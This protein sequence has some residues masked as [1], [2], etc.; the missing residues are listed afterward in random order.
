MVMKD[1]EMR[2]PKT[3]QDIKFLQTGKDTNGALLEM[4]ATYNSNSKEPASHYH[5]YQVEDFTVLKGELSVRINGELKI[6]KEGKTL[7]IDANTVHSMWNHKKGK[8]VVNWKVRPAM[9]TENLLRT[10]TGLAIDGK[11]NKNGMPNVLQIALV[12]NKYS[13]VLRLSKPP[14]AFQKVLFAVLMPFS[15]LLGYRAVYKKYLSQ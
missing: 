10:M 2:N 5:P 15:Y 1:N 4:E 7:H 8:T 9:D 13:D 3:G 6:L 14:F 12:A 11:T